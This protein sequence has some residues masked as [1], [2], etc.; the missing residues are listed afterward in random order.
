LSNSNIFDAIIKYSRDDHETYGPIELWR[1]NELSSA[2]DLFSFLCKKSFRFN[3]DISEWDLKSVTTMEATF[4]YCH[5]FNADISQW[6]VSGVTSLAS[7]FDEDY[8]FDQDIGG[9]D[10]SNLKS[11]SK[12]FMFA[13]TFKADLRGWDTW[14]VS[15]MSFT[16][17]AAAWFNSDISTWSIQRV[18]N[19]YA[20][21]RGAEHF[22]AKL[23]W[24]PKKNTNTFS[25]FTN[26]NGAGFE[27]DDTKCD[28]ELL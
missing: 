22:G 21:F 23:C 13:K 4:E 12:T 17:S 16:F 1:T 7:T 14:K 20:M 26:T 15:D 27:D 25:M 8:I 24:N 19:M 28:N 18:T 2:K 11:L 3:A 5:Y 6:D 9:W 10:T